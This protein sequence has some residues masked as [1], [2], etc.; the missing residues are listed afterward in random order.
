MVTYSLTK[1]THLIAVYAPH[2]CDL[3]LLAFTTSS[4]TLTETQIQSII[5]LIQQLPLIKVEAPP[6][7][8]RHTLYDK[9]RP[10]HPLLPKNELIGV[11][12]T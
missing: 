4:T 6:H 2:A 8:I 7:P 5:K 12:A 9:G 3:F 1:F 11:Q 10:H